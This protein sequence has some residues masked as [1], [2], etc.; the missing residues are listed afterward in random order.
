MNRIRNFEFCDCSWKKNFSD[1]VRRF[2]GRKMASG[3]RGFKVLAWQ[4]ENPPPPFYR[5]ES[6]G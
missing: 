3:D 5:K 1:S 2:I 4:I 6:R